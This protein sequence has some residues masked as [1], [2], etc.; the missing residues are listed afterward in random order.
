MSDSEQKPDV[1]PQRLCGEI[2]LFDLCDLNS[3]LHKNGHFCTNPVLLDRFE[4]ITDGEL[5][6]PERYI[7]GKFDDAESDDYDGDEEDDEFAMEDSENSDD[8]WEDK[9]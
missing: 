5:R 8:G 7:S 9:E 3:C 2:Q 1:P 6:T 4:K